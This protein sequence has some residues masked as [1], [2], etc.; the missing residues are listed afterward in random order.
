MWITHNTR[1]FRGGYSRKKLVVVEESWGGF[2]LVYR[3]CY[4]GIYRCRW[5]SR[6]VWVMSNREI[7]RPPARLFITLKV[8]CPVGRSTQSTLVIAQWWMWDVRNTPPNQHYYLSLSHHIIITRSTY[9]YI[10]EKLPYTGNLSL[11]SHLKF[12][13]FVRAIPGLE[14]QSIRRL[15]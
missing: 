3:S 11:P 13:R 8:F 4:R 2:R 9:T 10:Q 7:V 12:S 1:D 15:I 14:S 5:L 6:F